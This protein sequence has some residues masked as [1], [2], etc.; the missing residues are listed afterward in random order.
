M[1]HN[2]QEFESNRG[3]IIA[4]SLTATFMVVE[5]VGGILS[6]SMSLIGDAGHMLVDVLSLGISLFALNLAKRPATT[7][8]TFGFHR[9]EILAAL[10]NG[11]IL[12][13]V[14]VFVFYES[15]RRLQS[16]PEVKSTLMIIIAVIGLAANLASILL[17]RRERHANLNIRGAFL[18]IAGDAISSI[19]VIVAGIV[20]SVTGFR[21]ADPIMAIIIGVIILVGAVQLVGESTQILLEAVPKSMNMDKVIA[22]IKGVKGVQDIHDFHLWTITSGIYALSAHIMLEDQQ[23]SNAREIINSIND[24][25]KAKYGITH[26]TLQTEC[27]KCDSCSQ[28][29]VCQMARIAH[30]D[31]E[32]GDD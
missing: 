12:I 13:L 10:A 23:L 32:D 17:L 16:P 11:T 28:G 26:T 6:N 3:L 27:E 4:L 22:S 1:A 24:E 18:H 9:A 21:A 7:S 25:L 5:L 29:L 2:H 30:A 8:R 20:V 31:E 15:V 19:G 14:S